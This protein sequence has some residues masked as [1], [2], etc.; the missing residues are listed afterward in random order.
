ML[1]KVLV[2]SLL[3]VIFCSCQRTVI[4]WTVGDIVASSILILTFI[5]LILLYVVEYLQKVNK[6]MRKK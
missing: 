2:A 4:V 5:I 1:K 3:I 6:K